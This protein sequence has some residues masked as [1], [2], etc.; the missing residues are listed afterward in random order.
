MYSV[1]AGVTECKNSYNLYYLFNYSKHYHRYK[2]INWNQWAIPVQCFK[3][4]VYTGQYTEFPNL[5]SG[6][7]WF[8]SFA[9]FTKNI[10]SLP[11]VGGMSVKNWAVF[12]NLR[13]K[14]LNQNKVDKRF[15]NSVYCPV[16]MHMT[17]VLQLK[18]HIQYSSNVLKGAD[19][20]FYHYYIK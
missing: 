4:L 17:T 11:Q 13:S 1:L 15:R 8:R 18:I 19:F 5:L 16:F 14:I 9:T 12:L 10:V 3:I 7:F 20:L 2:F 6:L